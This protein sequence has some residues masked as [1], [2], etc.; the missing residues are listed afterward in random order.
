MDMRF[1]LSPTIDR[2]ARVLVRTVSRAGIVVSNQPQDNWDWFGISVQVL[3]SS[4]C[5]KTDPIGVSVYYF[6]I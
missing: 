2:R 5:L 1:V 4:D 3:E 6:F